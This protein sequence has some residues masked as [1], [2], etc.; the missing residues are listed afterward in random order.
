[1]SEFSR[2][3]GVCVFYIWGILGTRA[4]FSHV[5]GS[6]LCGSLFKTK[7]WKPLAPGVDLGGSKFSRSEF[8][9]FGWTEFLGL[10][11]EV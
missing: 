5:L 7:N 11:S 1:M 2:F 9:G 10:R 8:F 4:Y 3:G 6:F